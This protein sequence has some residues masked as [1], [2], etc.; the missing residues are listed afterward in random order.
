MDAVDTDPTCAVCLETSTDSHALSCGHSFHVQCIVDW[1]R[2]GS[3]R[4]PVCRDSGASPEASSCSDDG[5]SVVY[6]EFN[7]DFRLF[8]TRAEVAELV[9]PSLTFLRRHTQVRSQGMRRLRVR[10]TRYLKATNDANDARTRARLFLQAHSGP[11]VAGVNRYNAL[12][13]MWYTRERRLRDSAM[14]LEAEM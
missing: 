11:L 12:L 6:T 7:H 4:C 13:R 3:N 9:R 14:T 1:F 8:S 5:L 10:A 2:T